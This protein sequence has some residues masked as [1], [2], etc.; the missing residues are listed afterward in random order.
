MASTID[1][2]R[3]TAQWRL[4]GLLELAVMV[5]LFSAALTPAFRIWWM[6]R[7]WHFIVINVMILASA[8]AVSTFVFRT[9]GQTVKRAGAL[10]DLFS[11][12]ATREWAGRLFTMVALPLWCV[13][14][15]LM[16]VAAMTQLSGAFP[17]RTAGLLVLSLSVYLL[18]GW[19]RVGFRPLALEVRDHGM[20]LDGLEFI[21]WSNVLRFTVSDGVRP[22]LH[23]FVG[24]SQYVQHIPLRRAD[25]ARI[26][27]TLRRY[28]PHRSAEEQAA[29]DR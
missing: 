15:A 18:F 19:R 7:E 26:Q 1:P 21:P 3:H 25:A 24:P 10:I 4:L 9:R 2:R 20:L 23:V 29:T 14:P 22:V 11:Q 8:L 5:A 28:V 6:R 12:R 16:A 13:F 17:G 27:A